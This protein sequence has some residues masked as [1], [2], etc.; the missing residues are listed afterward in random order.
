MKNNAEILKLKAQIE[1]L[2]TFVMTEDGIFCFPNGEFLY[3]CG[4]GDND[5]IFQ[6][7]K[8]NDRLKVELETSLA[9]NEILDSNWRKA[10][11]TLSSENET[12]RNRRKK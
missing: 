6:L 2:K 8:E 9:D 7:K 12:L 10:Y 4:I 5:T 11:E 1:Y 3:G